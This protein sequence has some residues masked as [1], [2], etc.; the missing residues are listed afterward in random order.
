MDG[1]NKYI[2]ID[3]ILSNDERRLLFDYVKIF[4]IS[5]KT[6]FCEQ[7]SLGETY[8]YGDPIA[9]SLLVSK[10]DIFERASKLKLIE[11]YSYWRLYKKFSTLKK[12]TDRDSCEV[13]VSVNVAADVEWPLFIDIERIII[14]P[15]DGVLYFGAKSEHWR[16]EYEGDHS[17]QIFLHY[18]LEDGKFKN[19]KWDG[20]PCLG[21][22]QSAL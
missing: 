21:V 9:D 1:L 13:T 12:H 20:R 7:C 5:N 3:N 8:K 19:N 6:N 2:Y 14:N 4:N 16:E 18:V 22:L 10:K 15:G 11:T 17:L